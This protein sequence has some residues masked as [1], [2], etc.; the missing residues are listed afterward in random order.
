MSSVS[1]IGGSASPGR[2]GPDRGCRPPRHTG[3]VEDQISA[4]SPDRPVPED[5]R[6]LRIGEVAAILGIAE[7]TIRKW[8][9]RGDFPPPLR[10][11]RRCIR[12]TRQQIEEY[13]AAAA[14]AQRESGRR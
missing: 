3:R 14:A 8:V 4:D 1:D 10:I 12:W 6:L 11:G 5:L 13:I 9:G 2:D 7:V